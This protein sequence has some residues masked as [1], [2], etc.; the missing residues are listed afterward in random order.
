[1]SRIHASVSLRNLKT[2]SNVCV[3]LAMHQRLLLPKNKSTRAEGKRHI[4]HAL[5]LE[6][7]RWPQSLGDF[8]P[9]SSKTLRDFKLYV[10][11][12]E[13]LMRVRSPMWNVNPFGGI[14]V[15]LS[16]ECEVFLLLWLASVAWQRRV[17]CVHH[18]FWSNDYFHTWTVN[19]FTTGHETSLYLYSSF[20]PMNMFLWR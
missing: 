15:A 3:I 18:R 2:S 5:V 13:Q 16:I 17:V 19:R 6:F 1:M 4:F 11:Q 8:G 12:N 9:V 14:I 20:Y 7:S 10:P